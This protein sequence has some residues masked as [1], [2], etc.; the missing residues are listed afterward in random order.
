M[1]KKT[2]R[3][4]LGIPDDPKISVER[5]EKDLLRENLNLVRVDIFYIDDPILS[6]AAENKVAYLKKFHD[7]CKDT[8]IMERIKFLINKQ[9]LLTLQHSRDGTTDIMGSACI[10]GIASVKDDFER[11][12]SSYLKETAPTTNFNKYKII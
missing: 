11:M 6:V 10:N 7:I 4:L 1:F 9:A 5:M 3:K 12:G 8:E 2:I